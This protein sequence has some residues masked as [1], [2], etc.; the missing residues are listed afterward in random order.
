MM[1]E[2]WFVGR[3]KFDMST[4]RRTASRVNLQKIPT[5]YIFWPAKK[6]QTWKKKLPHDTSS[7]PNFHPNA[8]R[9]FQD[10]STWRCFPR[11][12]WWH[13]TAFPEISGKIAA[14]RSSQLRGQQVPWVDQRGQQ[15]G[16]KLGDSNGTT[17][18]GQY[19]A[20]PRMMIIPLFIFIHRVLTIPAGAGFLPSTV[21]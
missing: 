21:C 1:T 12:R 8:F 13:P 20:P 18:D 17:V 4:W 5:C 10:T 3:L 14:A 7:I 2:S 9:N 16:S 15:L 11:W 6:V 19:P